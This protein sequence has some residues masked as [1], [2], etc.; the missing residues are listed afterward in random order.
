LL[1]EEKWGAFRAC[2]AFIIP[3]HTENYCIAAVESLACGLPVLMSDRVNIHPMVTAHGAGYVEPDDE[4]GCL[5]LIERWLATS[6]GEWAAMR[7]RAEV[8]FRAEFG[9]GDAYR[10]F[11]TALSAVARVRPAV[12]PGE[13]DARGPH[14]LADIL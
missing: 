10:R 3:S 1:G 11:H 12:L 8:C 9:M 4:A 7:S 14:P 2:D 13:T 6:A 5:R